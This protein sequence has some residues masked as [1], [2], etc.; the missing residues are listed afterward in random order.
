VTRHAAPGPRGARRESPTAEQ[1]LCG[2]LGE[3]RAAVRRGRRPDV[4]LS[5]I[6]RREHPDEAMRRRLVRASAAWFRWSRVLGL[7][8]DS[9]RPRELDRMLQLERLAGG[10]GGPPAALELAEF[11][12]DPADLLPGW[13]RAG[14]PAHTGASALS[15]ALL[16]PP[17]VWLRALDEPRLR[18]GLGGLAESL[19]P[20]P[21]LPGAWRLSTRE[22]LYAT[23]GFRGGAFVLQDPASQAIGVACGAR[24]GEHWLDLCAGA[25]GKSLQLAAAME[26]KGLVHALDIHEGR[27][28]ELRRR[29][30]RQGVFNL[31]PRHWDGQTLPEL[32]RLRGVL[33]DAPCSGSGTLRRNPDLWLR[34]VPDLV[35]LTGI[36][37]SL[38]E[39]AA[40]LLSTGGRLVYATC[41]VLVAEN[42]TRVAAFQ[43]RHPDWRVIRM[44]H[45]LTGVDVDGILRVS[46]LDG[47]HD[48]TFV[49]VLERN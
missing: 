16:R 26:G 41:S 42:E 23:E 4:E 28:E 39:R 33:V 32:P 21:V 47:D 46:P 37:D 31:M 44:P 11:T 8:K 5:A 43:E 19:A 7:D 14:L 35:Q 18:A 13:I 10:P 12:P 48:G 40:A 38:L 2:W 15:L 1:R 30:R 6:L 45:P 27:L 17:T 36:Q 25:G 3:L 49:A 34:S 24:P 29:A 20:H 22:D 9:V